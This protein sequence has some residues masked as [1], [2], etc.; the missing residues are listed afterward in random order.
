MSEGS[1]KHVITTHACSKGVAI[2][3]NSGDDHTTLMLAH[4]S[5]RDDSRRKEGNG[6]GRRMGDS[7]NG[8]RS[9]RAGETRGMTATR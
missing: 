9:G 4:I 7:N 2:A 6:P 8:R 5:R 3:V 1:I